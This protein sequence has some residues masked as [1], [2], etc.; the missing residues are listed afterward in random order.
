MT[1]MSFEELRRNPEDVLRRIR[2]GEHFLVVDADQP[3]FEI[4]PVGHTSTGRRKL[5]L[6]AGDFA[7]PDDFDEPLPEDVLAGFEGR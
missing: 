5:G 2:A 3:L 1:E 6:C 7:V 4:H